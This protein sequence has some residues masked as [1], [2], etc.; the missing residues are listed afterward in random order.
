MDRDN[1]GGIGF[2]YLSPFDRK[3]FLSASASASAW[4]RARIILRVEIL[5]MPHLET[6]RNIRFVVCKE[7]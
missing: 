1:A 4:S 3:G 5:S 2:E 6:Q 7:S